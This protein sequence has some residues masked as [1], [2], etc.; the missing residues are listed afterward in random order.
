MIQTIV[1]AVLIAVIVGLL[2]TLLG[3]V[4][5]TLAVPI[6]VTVGGFL[7]QYGWTIGV[8]AGL[9]YIVTG[10]SFFPRK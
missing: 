9:W 3:R 6:A 4:L 8:I 1:L 2:A 10:G 5:K 7:E